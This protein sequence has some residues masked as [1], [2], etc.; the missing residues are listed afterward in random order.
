MRTG[1]CSPD[2]STESDPTESHGLVAIRTSR[3]EL[4]TPGEIDRHQFAVVRRN[5][6]IFKDRAP[7]SLLDLLP[8]A[9]ATSCSCGL[10]QQRRYHWDQA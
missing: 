7:L 5:A 2:V 4:R 8:E 10:P 1:V 6:D 3:L 9:P